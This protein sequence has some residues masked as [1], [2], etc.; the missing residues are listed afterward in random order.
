MWVG[1]AQG[2]AF[3]MPPLRRLADKIDERDFT[4]NMVFLDNDP[5]RVQARA[6]AAMWVLN[7]LLLLFLALAVARTLSP[8]AA[9]CV[10]AFLAIDPTIAA[11]LPVVMTDLSVAVLSGAAVLFVVQALRGGRKLDAVLAAAA[12]GFSGNEPLQ[13]IRLL[14]FGG[15]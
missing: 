3:Q 9:V 5:A 10:T 15:E 8:I 11:H 12:L 2:H 1:A 4:E 14:R 7:T 6:R 13:N